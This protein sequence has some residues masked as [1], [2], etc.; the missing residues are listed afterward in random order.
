MN[1]SHYDEQ[2]VRE[3]IK[4]IVLSGHPFLKRAC[5]FLHLPE[6]FLPADPRKYSVATATQLRLVALYLLQNNLVAHS[7]K[8][9][10]RSV[11]Q[12]IANHLET[13]KRELANALKVQQNLQVLQQ[14][15]EARLRAVTDRASHKEQLREEK[16]QRLEEER[17]LASALRE[18]KLQ[19]VLSRKHAEADRRER[20]ALASPSQ[21]IPL[22][23]S[24]PKLRQVTS[25]RTFNDE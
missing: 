17:R 9:H 7:P 21:A 22:N 5:E 23:Q 1:A 24:L 20:Q 12:P 15:Q 18:Q 25:R 19:G 2:R 13:K 8:P 3:V 11:P 10:T 16:R 14:Q 4:E 6:D